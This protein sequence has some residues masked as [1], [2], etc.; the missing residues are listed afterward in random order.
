MH[1]LIDCLI[2]WLID[3]LIDWLVDWLID[4]FTLY[5]DTPH[6]GLLS[7]NYKL[8]NELLYNINNLI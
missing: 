6:K 2:D 7:D 8:L 4:W 3:C 5:I 1:W